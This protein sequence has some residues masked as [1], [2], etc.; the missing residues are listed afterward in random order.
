LCR[1]RRPSFDACLTD[2]GHRETRSLTDGKLFSRAAVWS[3]IS[4]SSDWRRTDPGHALSSSL[5][6]PTG[7]L[8][9]KARTSGTC[10]SFVSTRTDGG[11]ASTRCFAAGSDAARSWTA[12]CSGR[13]PSLS[14]AWRAC[15][16]FR[17][18][19]STTS[20]GGASYRNAACSGS[21]PS[22]SAARRAKGCALTTA[23]TAASAA[24]AADPEDPPSP[25][26]NMSCACRHARC[27][28]RY[29]SSSSVGSQADSGHARTMR[30]T[31]L[32]GAARS[33]ARWI[34]KRPASLR[35]RSISGFASMT[36]R[37]T[38][39]GSKFRIASTI[40]FRAP[41]WAPPLSAM[42]SL[43]GQLWAGTAPSTVQMPMQGRGRCTR[44]HE[45]VPELVSQHTSSSS[46]TPRLCS[47]AGNP[48]WGRF[49]P[50]SPEECSAD[51]FV[52]LPGENLALR[53]T[54]REQRENETVP[55]FA[56]LRSALPCDFGS[57]LML[58]LLLQLLL[59]LWLSLADATAPTKARRPTM[60]SA[61]PLR[62]DCQ[63]KKKRPF[64][65]M[66]CQVDTR[67]RSRSA[68]WQRNPLR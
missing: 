67:T 55:F 50:L 12:W 48:S 56:V 59:L 16:C 24:A 17:T 47:G 5:T 8:I 39:G 18:R 54:T 26:W 2:S 3:G 40:G 7:A 13:S 52:P 38:L 33:S 29:L 31:T 62:S 53:K 4:P 51:S 22:A 64:G 27:A 6:T 23:L 21:L 1:A 57:A 45:W 11:H 10:P 28:G 34:G 15:G 37:T 49:P 14:V 41:G 46:P 36:D 35:L 25:S 9:I 66:Q 58:L 32:G 43:A 19:F 20:R 44:F 68:G 42:I 30:R 65:R 63:S 61:P 60:V